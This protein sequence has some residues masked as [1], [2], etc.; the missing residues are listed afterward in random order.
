MQALFFSI[1]KMT[2]R[3]IVGNEIDVHE[4]RVCHNNHC[5]FFSPFIIVSGN[6]INGQLSS[7]LE[8]HFF[9]TVII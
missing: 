1:Q 3:T 6:A 4:I 2:Q 9:Y 7:F 8:L 5:A